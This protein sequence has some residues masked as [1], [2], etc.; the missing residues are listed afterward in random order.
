MRFVE[1]RIGWIVEGEY[2]TSIPVG[3]HLTNDE[4]LAYYHLRPGDERFAA[5]A[6]AS[7]YMRVVLRKHN[8]NFIVAPLTP[9]VTEITA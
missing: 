2:I 1:R 8:G 9:D 3:Q 5:L 4:M 6:R 7:K